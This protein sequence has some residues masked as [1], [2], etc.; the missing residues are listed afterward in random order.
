[1]SQENVEIVRR[2]V[3]AGNAEDWRGNR[4]L[5]FFAPDWVGHALP[6]WPGP[7]RWEGH[8]GLRALLAEWTGN[9]DEFRLEVAEDVD[10]DARVLSR[11]KM[12]GVAKA[13]GMPVTTSLSAISMFRDG[14]IVDTRWFLSWKEALK[15]VGLEE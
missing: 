8:D 9:F 10:N 15:A 11:L 4:V 1:M 2:M 14:K 12:S 6:E 5:D 7:Q 3:Q 13:S